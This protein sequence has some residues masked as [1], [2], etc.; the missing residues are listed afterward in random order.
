MEVLG[1][2]FLGILQ[3]S[4]TA[5]IAAIFVT[6]LFK[7]FNNHIGVR[8]KNILLILI[9]VKFLI[10]VIPETNIS[11]FSIVYQK[12][13]NTLQLKEESNNLQQVKEPYI[14]DKEKSEDNSYNKNTEVNLEDEVKNTHKQN[15]IL[16]ILKIASR[17]WV[18]GT[19]I[20]ILTLLLFTFNFKRKTKHL[21]SNM[22]PEIQA[23]I[24][25][26]KHKANISSNI[27]VY[28]Y[29]GFKSPCILGVIR[30]KIYIPEYILSTNDSNQLSHIF[31]HELM[32]YKRKDLLYNFLGII[33][34]SIHWF[35]P[36]AWF[37]VN[38]MKIYREFACDTCV[39][40]L[41]GEKETIEYGMT[42]INLSKMFANK[43]E[44]SR[45]AVFFE[46]K[47]QIKGRIKMIKQFKPGSY[48]MSILGIVGC[49]IASAVIFTNS[50]N[51]KALDVN[52]STLINE[53]NA[54]STSK[55]PKFLVDTPKKTYDNIEK[56]VKVAG[57]KFKVPDFPKSSKANSLQ[58][59]KLSDQ[60]N[61]LLI[62]LDGD[63]NFT[64][65]VSEKD[66]LE[67]LKKIETEKNHLSNLKVESEEQSMKLGEIDGFSVTVTATSP[68][69]T[70]K[71]GYV[72]PEFKEVDKYFA[73]KN[74]GLWYSIRYDSI[75]IGSG[76]N[77]N[78]SYS[79]S[80]EDIEKIV[81]SIVYPEEIKNVNYSVKKDVST[82]VATMMIYEKEDLE[83]AKGLL[84]FNPKFPL[85][86]NEDIKITGS[87]V[88]ISGD[89]DIENNKIDY[90][91]ANF[92]SNKKGSLTFTAEKNSK[93]YKDIMKNGYINIWD[94]ENEKDKEVKGE[95]LSINN[96]EVFKCL[97]TEKLED[98]TL[99]N[100]GEYVWEEDNIYYSVAFWENIDNSD[101]VVAEFI[102]SKTID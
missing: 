75:F 48:K 89:S 5:S 11:L 72:R 13:Q 82:E 9:L 29:D 67:Y 3:A 71:N 43:N 63:I 46:T 94:M 20:I 32:H 8:V 88:G 36:I 64:F 76:E 50:M 4:L 14:A 2:I 39:L 35:N 69:E 26:C 33:A 49:V 77:G 83:K 53:S 41:L 66:P 55:T 37:A 56:V 30:P 7:I 18:I 86:I 31:L 60:D 81:K 58:L 15:L 51:V 27:P 73:W 102:N 79:I 6:V 80:Q 45:F 97:Y 54:I 22:H 17:V 61:V 24:E 85:K 65:Q 74:D 57:F 96:H 12:Y 34:L 28:I 23:L 62:Y 92:Y 19:S 90:E 99:I 68:A 93:K 21:E 42:L 70:M 101:E 44:Y 47:N 100:N 95:K 84:G 87:S 91:L 1:K 98:G 38:K 16:H 52:S 59:I 25:V 40:E 10:P 78:Q